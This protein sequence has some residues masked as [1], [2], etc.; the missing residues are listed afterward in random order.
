M[1]RA[2]LR[3]PRCVV[4]SLTRS[5]SS[6]TSRSCSRSPA[7][8][9]FPVRAGITPP[10]DHV[11]AGA[12]GS[13]AGSASPPAPHVLELHVSLAT[14]LSSDPPLQRIVDG[15]ILTSQTSRDRL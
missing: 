14:S 8:Y 1:A 2:P 5:P 13:A 6:Q 11:T 10:V 7:R 4:G 3:K 12:Y 15:K 9:C